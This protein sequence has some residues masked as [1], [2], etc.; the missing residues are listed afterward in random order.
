MCLGQVAGNREPYS[1]ELIQILPYFLQKTVQCS[2]GGPVVKL[3]HFWH[4]NPS[5]LT[6]LLLGV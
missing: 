3:R 4:L 2:Y 6:A 5:S 1:S